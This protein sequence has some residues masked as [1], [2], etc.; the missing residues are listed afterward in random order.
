[1]NNTLSNLPPPPKGQTGVTLDSLKHLPPPPKGQKGF[2]LDEITKPTPQPRG[3]GGSIYDA[4]KSVLGGFAAGVGGIALT[5]EDYVARKAVN[6][7]GTPQM[8]E[9]L[10]KAPSLNEQFKQRFGG[11]KNPNTYGLGQLGG[12]IASLAMPVG[13]VGKAAKVGSEA[14]G[15]GKLLTKVVQAGAEGAAFTAGQG[16]TEGKS[17]SLSDYA[18]NTGLN[19]A[20]PIGGVALKS[21]AERLPSRI[22][23]SLIKPLAKDFAYEKN[24]GET[25]ARLGIIGNSFDELIGGIKTNLQNIGSRI[26]NLVL[27]SPNLAKIELSSSLNPLDE[28]ISVANK[29]PRTNASVIQRLE[30]VKADLLDNITK[31]IDPQAFK[32]LVGDLTKWTGNASDDKAVNKALKQVYG[33]TRQSMDDVLSKEL[34][35]EQFKAYKQDTVD[36]GNLLSAK[37]AAEHRDILTQ[38]QDLISFGAK[39]AGVIG[40]LTSMLHFGV[41][42]ITAL[43]A[44]A[45]IV[46]DKAAATPAFKTRLATLLSKIPKGDVT[47]FFEKV[48]TAKT[49]FTEQDIKNFGNKIVKG[50]QDTPNK[51]GG[52]IKLPSI[53]SDATKNS[54]STID[55]K[56]LLRSKYPS[57]KLDIYEKDGEINLSRIEVPKE[58]R[59]QKIGTNAMNNLIKYAD[60]T[61]Q[62]ITLTPSTDFGA[63]S[64]SRLTEFYKRFGFKENKG[65]NKDFQT[66][67]SMVRVPNSSKT[68]SVGSIKK[69][70]N[71]KNK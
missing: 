63:S 69:A 66:R 44:L 70:A 68:P 14:L 39:N 55:A 45:G 8:K 24:P 23:N 17:P 26:G 36:Y 60:E 62:K 67:E 71:S 65:I 50:Y 31:G 11:D 48:P 30:G 28:A 53:I 59:G 5:A 4:G 10:N 33:S 38:R 20:F 37:N 35:P 15:G 43:G 3:I 56:N 46:I 21:I 6:A 61:N 47:T 27:K 51:Q 9:N 57:L 49:L 41:S 64:K 34:T 1:M 42:P 12:E 40:A 19:M 13:A 52:F 2:R 32:G 29:A 54:D 22:I 25:V 58:N 16:L 7:F 18:I